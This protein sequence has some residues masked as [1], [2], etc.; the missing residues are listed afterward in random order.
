MTPPTNRPARFLPPLGRFQGPTSAP[1]PKDPR[2]SNPI[3][4]WPLLPDGDGVVAP[5]RLFCHSIVMCASLLT[6]GRAV[7]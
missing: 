7:V 5:D 3:R 4:L 1:R 2:S 6:A